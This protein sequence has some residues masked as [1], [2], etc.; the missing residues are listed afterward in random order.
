MLQGFKNFITEQGLFNGEH[1]LLLAL[2]GGEDSVCLFHLLSDAGYRFSV[3]HCNFKLRGDES[4][5]DER[6]V[7]ELAISRQIVCHNIS[8]NTAELSAEMGTGIQET[9]RKLR[10][11]WFF[12]LMKEHGYHKL[13]TAHHRTDNLETMLINI[14]RGS[15]VRGLHGIPVDENKIARPLMFT[16]KE[17]ID[18]YMR[19]NQLEFREDRSNASDY[20]LRNALRHFVLPGLKNVRSDAEQRFYETG[21]KVKSYESISDE[22]LQKAWLECTSESDGQLMIDLEKMGNIE[23]KVPFLYYNLQHYGFTFKQIESIL[24]AEQVGKRVLSEKFMLLV[25]RGQFMVVPIETT[26][27]KDI[28]MELTVCPENEFEIGDFQLEMRM[29]P[30]SE[31]LDFKQK[32]QLFLSGDQP[33]WP[34]KIRQ[35]REGDKLIPLGM[36]GY[37]KVSDILTDRKVPNH[38]RRQ[39]LVIENIDNEIIALLPEIIHESYKIQKDT[40]QIL[41]IGIKIAAK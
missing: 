31:D 10:Y 36:K 30:K 20:Y 15:G 32:Q 40:Q 34:L 13:L 29:I 9:A 41:S 17:E 4:D 6:F 2:S 23:H 38:L 14:L 22:L 5:A 3:A 28:L 8:F 7:N 1:K 24:N 19:S 25:E 39:F 21:T 37:K 11:D 35:W 16:T 18:T 26:I 33:L 12:D 27:D